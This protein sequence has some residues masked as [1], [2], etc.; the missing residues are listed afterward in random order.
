MIAMTNASL[1]AL[2]D[3]GAAAEA[4]TLWRDAVDAYEQALTAASQAPPDSG[5]DEA[6][7]LTALGRCYWNLSDARTGWRTLRRA[8]SLCQ[9]RGDAIAQA[10][11]TLE[12]VRIW[13]PPERLSAMAAEALTA[14]GDADPGLRARLLLRHR[15]FTDDPETGYAEAMSLAEQYGIADVLAAR[16]ERASWDALDS[17]DLDAGQA[18]AEEA[19]KAFAQ[20]GCH[21][22]AAYV[23]RNAGFR[24]IELGA[25]DRGYALAERSRQYAEATH[26][27]FQSQ[28][29]LLDLVG[30][31]FGR[32]DFARCE[33][34]LAGA[35]GEADIR[36]D[37]FRMWIAEEQGDGERVLRML[38]NP[39]RGGRATTAVG[40]IH[41]AAA[42]ALFRAGKTDAAA[43]A[44]HAW[45][46]VERR[47]EDDLAQEASALLE[48]LLALG[49]NETLQKVYRACIGGDRNPSG[50]VFSTL[51]GRAL[52]PLVGGLAL[53]LGL[54]DEA[55]RAYVDGLAFCDRERLP[56]DAARCRTG[57]AAV[58]A[59]RAG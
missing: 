31:A 30:V 32:G 58:E 2:V 51:L 59:A 50:A 7:V 36:A 53:K 39:E 1:S 21:T 52:A 41:A 48:C 13:G 40:Q 19:H 22:E 4:S 28:L 57:L 23:L 5:F 55:E 34:L 20:L 43:E 24:T 8:I 15:W 26:L 18:R 46:A 49:D 12:I 54:L 47:W 27:V 3:A 11:A 44:F 42:G 6:A 45:L 29:A 56:R 9:E 10:R 33:E 16:T 17:G 35:P 38:V 37:F 25:L 14:L